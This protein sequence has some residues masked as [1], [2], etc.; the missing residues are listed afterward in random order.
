[1]TIL[2][3]GRNIQQLLLVLCKYNIIKYT[4][5]I[6]LISYNL[7]IATNLKPIIINWVMYH[8]FAVNGSMRI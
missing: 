3:H 6:L 2:H 5:S 7:Y 1:M 4:S 8:Y